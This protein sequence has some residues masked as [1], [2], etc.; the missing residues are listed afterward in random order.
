MRELRL[1]PAGRVR[2]VSCRTR[3]DGAAGSGIRS[4]DSAVLSD[5]EPLEQRFS[6][7]AP[8][9]EPS[10]RTE[11]ELISELLSNWMTSSKA[12][13]GISFSGLA[14][15][16]VC[17]HFGLAQSPQ[18]PSSFGRCTDEEESSKST[19]LSSIVAPWSSTPNFNIVVHQQQ[20]YFVMFACLSRGLL[21]LR[22]GAFCSTSI[23]LWSMRRRGKQR[24][25]T[26]TCPTQSS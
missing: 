19:D 8:W 7:F 1:C 18:L 17:F 10:E 14:L 11:Q 2:F 21:R 12:T 6:D 20:G 15:P 4:S 23:Q 9:A 24:G 13:Q 5:P 25:S 3:S 22:F 26:L 16:V